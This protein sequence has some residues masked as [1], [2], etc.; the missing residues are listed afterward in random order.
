[1]NYRRGRADAVVITDAAPSSG[2]ELRSRQ[3]RYAA[4]M[5]VH[6]AG[7][8]LAGVLYYVAWWLGLVLMIATGALPWIAVVAAND[9]TPRPA[10]PGHLSAHG[11]AGGSA[12][13]DT[14]AQLADRHPA[15]APDQRPQGP[16]VLEAHPGGHRVHTEDA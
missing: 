11:V 16:G 8:A 14:P 6:I 15:P 2:D 9:S 7:F 12:R 1:M 13:G 5:A 10:R 3:R 4:L